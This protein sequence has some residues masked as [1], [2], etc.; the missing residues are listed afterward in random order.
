MKITIL[1][2]GSRGDVQPYVALGVGLK[3]A[4][5]QVC[6]PAPEV[7][8][9]LICDAGLDF[10]PLRGF[11]PQEFIRTPEI[12]TAV[13]QGGQLKILT[14]LLHEAGPLLEG[15]FDEYWRTSAG[16]DLLIASSLV[17][18][19]PD[20]AEK[21]GIPLIQAP[22]HALLAPTRAFPSAFFAPWGAQE[23]NF[24]NPITHKIVQFA[25]WSICR[26][27]L[28][29]W[30]LKMG[31]PRIDNYFQH[32]Q[33]RND[34]TLYGFSPSVL[35]TPE[36]WPPNH[37]VTGYWFLEPPSGWRPPNALIQFLES[38]PPPV[39]VG[40]GS[41][42][43]QDPAR[44]T[45]LVVDSL[46]ASG[47]RGVLASGWGGLHT[48]S[49]P[50]TIFSIKEIPHSW[51]FPRMA[52]LIHHGGMGTTAA[53]LR[54]GL[55]AVIIP[56]G[57]DQP[58]W[59]DR[60]QRLGVGIRSANHFKITTKRL[61]ADIT[62]AVCDTTLRGNTAALGEKIRAEHGVEIVGEDD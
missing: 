36:D 19:I 11:D 2:Q 49:L 47:Q 3:N 42:D 43:T 38:G 62:R 30:R 45:R 14:S 18:G 20:C 23:N 54:A 52:A 60:L 32:M 57:G 10:I 8:R 7:F 16:A 41:M 55:P 39:Y 13:R 61:T 37:R 15:L 59:A 5:Y 25:F 6:M 26:A 31:L 40:F 9:Q 21:H 44:M 33:A 17:F 28:N 1:A 53:G 58:F 22:I 56:L 29:H 48:E 35:P 34:P 4:G 24:A 51:L 27:A 50:D 46:V 12:Q